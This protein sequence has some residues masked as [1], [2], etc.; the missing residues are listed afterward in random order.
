MQCGKPGIL[1]KRIDFGIDVHQAQRDG[2]LGDRPF[3]FCKRKVAHSEGV[4]Q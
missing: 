3:E 1:A 4:V 2:I